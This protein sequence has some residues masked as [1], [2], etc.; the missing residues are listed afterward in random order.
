MLFYLSN[1]PVGVGDSFESIKLL[2]LRDDQQ[3]RS[4][5]RLLFFSFSNIFP[6]ANAILSILMGN[7]AHYMTFTIIYWFNTI[8]ILIVHLKFNII[9]KIISQFSHLYLNSSKYDYW[10]HEDT[11]CLQATHKLVKKSKTIIPFAPK[12]M[13]C[14]LLKS[15][16]KN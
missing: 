5:I 3:W 4:L 13:S 2:S 6:P 14:F 8:V 16:P 7:I 1:T 11:N 10:L 9:H 12:W 15:Q